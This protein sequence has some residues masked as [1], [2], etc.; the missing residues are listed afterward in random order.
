MP[1]V[2][3][4]FSNFELWPIPQFTSKPCVSLQLEETVHILRKRI[5]PAPVTFTPEPP[6]AS[7]TDPMPIEEDGVNLASPMSTVPPPP[8]PEPQIEGEQAEQQ[9]QEDQVQQE[10]REEGQE[11]QQLP[12]P[13]SSFEDQLKP[14]EPPRDST[15]K[16]VFLP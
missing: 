12:P 9:Q 2:L 16:I 8:L 3:F 7:V 11:D 13:P 15:G 6:S 5:E 14:K 4:V 1:V 10:H